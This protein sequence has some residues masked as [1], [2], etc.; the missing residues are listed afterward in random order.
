M[1][2]RAFLTE[3]SGR[4]VNMLY[5]RNKKTGSLVC[6]NPKTDEV[7][8]LEPVGVGKETAQEA[9]D[10]KVETRIH[11]KRGRVKTTGKLQDFVVNGKRWSRKYD[12][13]QECR[14]TAVKHASKGLCRTCFDKTRQQ[15]KR[16]SPEWKAN[17]A[18]GLKRAKGK[19]EEDHDFQCNDCQDEFVFK[20]L[21]M[22]AVCP[23]CHSV[24]VTKI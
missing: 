16:G 12:E 18:V 21:I 13:C 3:D 1:L 8:E 22:D 6:Y 24:H 19:R 11:K 5:Y 14:T 10:Q 7:Q 20:G 17:Q 23:N 15:A 2:H 9:T 4:I